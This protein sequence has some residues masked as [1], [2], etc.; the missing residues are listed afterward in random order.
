MRV[1]SGSGGMGNEIHRCHVPAPS[2]GNPKA[3][4]PC[5]P[6]WKAPGDNARYELRPIEAPF[7]YPNLIDDL[8]R[9]RNSLSVEHRALLPVGHVEVEAGVFLV[10]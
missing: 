5:H 4:C 7:R 8:W 1:D 10:R 6:A 9:R 3:A 2:M